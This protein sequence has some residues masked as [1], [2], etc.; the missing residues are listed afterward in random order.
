MR[1]PQQRRL[2]VFFKNKKHS[3]TQR[4][5]ECI[6]TRF[7]P[8]CGKIPPLVSSL[9]QI[10]VMP[11]YF[12]HSAPKWYS[13]TA[14][15]GTLTAAMLPLLLVFSVNYCLHHCHFIYYL[16]VCRKSQDFFSDCKIFLIY[17]PVYDSFTSLTSSGV[18]H[19]TTVPPPFPP[20][21]PKSII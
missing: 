6:N 18:P 9:T 21:G 10:H 15:K 16:T 19:A 11:T 7:H 8:D 20:S 12:R 1:V 3:E 4:F 2:F 13:F 17:F 5:Q 14:A